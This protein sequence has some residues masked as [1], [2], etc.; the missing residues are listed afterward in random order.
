MTKYIAYYLDM[1]G[2]KIQRIEDN[3]KKI[4]NS[5]ILFAYRGEPKDYKETKLMPSLFRN[6]E[7]VSKERYLFELLGDY[8]VIDAG[9]NRYIEK[10]IEAQ[11]YVA[12]S[13]NLDIAFSVLPSLFFACNSE[14]NEDGILFVFGFPKYCSPHSGYIERVYRNI[15]EDG[16][17]VYDKNFRVMTH[18]R[19]N[20]R[21]YAQSGGFIFFPG[22]KFCP[23][24]HL[25]YE[26]VIIDKKHKKYILQ[27]LQTYFDVNVAKL[28]PE[29]NNDANIVKKLFSEASLQ[30]SQKDITLEGEIDYFFER[31]D[32]ETEMMRVT[33]RLDDETFF[34]ILRKE[35]DDLCFFLQRYEEHIIKNKLT[36]IN[37]VAISEY[38]DCVKDVERRFEMLRRSK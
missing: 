31:I 1:I 16:I 24:N 7:F 28:F 2:E 5:N 12:I 14:E 6:E 32:Y 19:Y 4:N 11:H 34:R 25:Y 9:K 8:N 29:K 26:E 22:K 15:L 33:G 20:E 35:K 13:R 37:D 27:E 18:S 23:I 30:D 10:S 36:G 38:S 17:S 21:I 3:N